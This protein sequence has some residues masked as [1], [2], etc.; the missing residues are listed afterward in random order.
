VLSPGFWS[1]LDISRLDE[2]QD[3]FAPLM[4][5]RQSDRGEMIALNLPDQIARRRWII[6]GPS[7]EGAFAD[8]Y[9]EQVEAQVR[10]LVENLPALIKLKRGEELNEADLND[11]ARALNQADLFITEDV[12]REVYQQP[13]ASLPEG[14]LFGST[15]A[16]IRLRRE[17]LTEHLV[18]AII[19]LPAG[20][21]Q[22]YIGV[23]T[24][25]LVFQK[26]TRKEDRDKWKPVN[27]PRTQS[28][29]FYEVTEEAYTLDAKRTERRGQNNDL[30]DALEK[31]Q[32]RYDPA[33]DALVYYQPS[34]EPQ[35]WRMVDQRTL[36]VFAGEPEVLRSKDRV[37]A[38][39]ELFADLSA[40]PQEA[41]QLIEQRE[42][43]ALRQLALACLND[44]AQEAKATIDL[45]HERS[46]RLEYARALLRK[47]AARFRTPC[48]QQRHLLFEE[49]SVA[50]PL[51]QKS[52]HIAL[53]W[54]IDNLAEQVVN[55]D[56]IETV[57]YDAT[58]FANEV[59]RVARN[60]AKLDGYDVMLRTLHVNKYAR[61]DDWQSE[62]GQIKGSHDEHDNVRPEYVA[63]IT[64][65]DEK[66]NL[67]EGLLDPDCIE[68]RGWN[69]STGQYKP[70]TFSTVQSDK[71]V[72]DMLRELQEKEQQIIVGIDKLLAMVEGRE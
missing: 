53:D 29:W 8:S 49:E 62:D 40:D 33:A 45:P 47:D 20:V 67:K 35:R 14:V 56:A 64:L 66:G 15:E 18:E 3:T 44:A 37:A 1:H 58:T 11:I 31:F 43:P 25:I 19:S 38:I 4:R 68:A 16:H 50:W 10:R 42:Q 65:Y 32:T 72:A 30:W 61:N 55:E 9:R 41:Q 24:S 21:F 46:E 13:A 28:V 59:R 63:S 52:F 69:L 17:L 54:A 36:E 22:P 23:K 51:F 39:H 57:D 12:L 71:S 6:Y 27:A 2:I 48:N 70:F 34:Y 60:F 7:G 26:E 5:F